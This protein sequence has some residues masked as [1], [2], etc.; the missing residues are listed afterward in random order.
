MNDLFIDYKNNL[1]VKL[2]KQS[3]YEHWTTIEEQYIIFCKFYS[4]KTNNNCF[5]CEKDISED[6]ELMIKRKIVKEIKEC[7]KYDK[8]TDK[9]EEEEYIG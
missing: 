4:N 7:D 8:E 1:A 3:K 2:L 5:L 6:E 9:E